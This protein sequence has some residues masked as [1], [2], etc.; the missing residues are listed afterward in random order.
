[1][2][3]ARPASI[4]LLGSLFLASSAAEKA[5]EEKKPAPAIRIILPLAMAKGATN[6]FEVRGTALTK[7]PVI[8]SGSNSTDLAFIIKTNGPATGAKKA[9]DKKAPDSYINASVFVPAN[10]S[11][12]NLSLVVRTKDGQS[13]PFQVQI[14]PEGTLILEKEPNN[15]FKQAQSVTIPSTVA[16]AI[17]EVGDVDLYKVTL[18]TGETLDLRLQASALG[19]PLDAALT[20]YDNLGHNLAYNDD[21]GTNRDPGLTWRAEKSGDY[22]IG[23][24]DSNDQGSPL[25]A[26]LLHLQTKLP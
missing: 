2:S 24:I 15:G 12:T 3:I 5:A 14:V 7:Q 10:T 1:M 25:H 18:K 11:G 21:T 23:V 17:K 13:E 22:L 19:S 6:H 4:I 16:G 9:D 20:L 8:L 26:Y